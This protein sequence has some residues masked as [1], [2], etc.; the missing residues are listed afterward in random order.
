M[1]KTHSFIV[2]LLVWAL[3]PAAAA[4]AAGTTGQQTDACTIVRDQA[5]WALMSEE[6]SIIALFDAD[7]ALTDA[8]VYELEQTLKGLLADIERERYA[9]D[10]RYEECLAAKGALE[11]K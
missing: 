1:A 6:K 4:A 11:P 5:L 2:A 7:A 8:P 10:D 9:V 3:L